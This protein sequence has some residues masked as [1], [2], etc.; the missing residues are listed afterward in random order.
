[1]PDKCFE[2]LLDIHPKL[3]FTDLTKVKLVPEGHSAVKRISA[4]LENHGDVPSL[5]RLV[6]SMSAHDSRRLEEQVG[7]E[8]PTT[9]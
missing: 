2:Y 7:I 3:L 4:G 5:F 8:N 9:E 1:M 6:K